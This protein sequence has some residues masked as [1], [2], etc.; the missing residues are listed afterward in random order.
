MPCSLQCLQTLLH[1]LMIGTIERQSA[2]L[3]MQQPLI[4]LELQLHPGQQL[5]LMP[6][7]PF[8]GRQLAPAAQACC[9]EET[10]NHSA[11]QHL[12]QSKSRFTPVAAVMAALMAAS[13]R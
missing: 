9:K 7:V 1:L 2:G 3:L 6:A 4:T 12:T 8:H 10:K 11:D 13:R 5:L